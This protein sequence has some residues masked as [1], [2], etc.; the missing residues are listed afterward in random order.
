MTNFRGS[1][2][3]LGERFCHGFFL[4]APPGFLKEVGFNIML[5]KYKKT[6]K[7][8]IEEKHKAKLVELAG[9]SKPRVKRK[10]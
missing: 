9:E 4:L 2:A 3:V 1:R 7:E 5:K 10:K 6:L 8:K